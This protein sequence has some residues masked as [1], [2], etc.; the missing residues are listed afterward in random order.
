MRGATT[1]HVP[2]TRVSIVDGAVALQWC[3]EQVLA[4]GE[5]GL[6]VVSIEEIVD[7]GE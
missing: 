2:W 3:V 5:R 1:A 4:L 7:E 6:S